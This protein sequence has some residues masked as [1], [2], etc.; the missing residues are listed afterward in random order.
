MNKFTEATINTN[1]ENNLIL[2]SKHIYR[3]FQ[4]SPI[5]ILLKLSS[6]LTNI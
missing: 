1:S 6:C 5:S 3:S 2:T 4:V